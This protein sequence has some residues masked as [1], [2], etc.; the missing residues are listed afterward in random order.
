M[1]PMFNAPF[2]T[3]HVTLFR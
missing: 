1:K 2:L 3:R